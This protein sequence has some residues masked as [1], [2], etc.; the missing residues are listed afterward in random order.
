MN[1]IGASE[2]VLYLAIGGAL[3]AAYFML[4]RYTLRLHAAGAGGGLLVSLYAGRIGAAAAAFWA[5]AQAGGL[6]LL[7]ALADFL[8]A[9]FAVAHGT[10]TD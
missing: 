8:V 7:L 6:P 4:L 1:A 3:G 2:I 5:I 9:R 10:R